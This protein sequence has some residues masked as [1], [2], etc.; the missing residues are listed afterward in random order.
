MLFYF[1]MFKYIFNYS[2]LFSWLSFIYLYESF[3]PMNIYLYDSLLKTILSCGCIPI[4]FIQWSIPYLYITCDKKYHKIIKLFETTYE[5]CPFH[6]I[7]YTEDLYKQEFHKDIYHDFENI[8][9]IASGS[10]GQVYKIKHKQSKKEYALKIIHPY[11]HYELFWNQIIIMILSYLCNMNQ[12]LSFNSLDFFKEFKK[13]GNF[14][15]EANNLL[16]FNHNYQLNPKIIIPE[17]QSV[18]KHILIMD[19]INGDSLHYNDYML[20][21][22]FIANNLHIYK[23]NHGDLHPGNFRIKNNKLIIYDFG[24]CW[25]ND[26]PDKLF[27]LFQDLVYYYS[28]DIIHTISHTIKNELFHNLYHHLNMDSQYINEIS[29]DFKQQNITTIDNYIL[30]LIHIHKKYHK[31]I[32]IS[33]INIFLTMLI[34]TKYSKDFYC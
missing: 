33:L 5:N 25:K 8:Q 14:I 30:F 31:I 26:I 11:I 18:S 13:Q 16:S 17:L 27:T 10:I 2:K 24:Y 15:N 29:K 19:F 21:T 6:S 3:Y 23:F 7:K 32:N 20:L 4:K 1:N 9:E 34:S 22:L 12:L 28:P